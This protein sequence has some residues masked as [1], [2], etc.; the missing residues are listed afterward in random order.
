VIQ[1]KPVKTTLDRRPWLASLGVRRPGPR[2]RGRASLAGT[3]RAPSCVLGSGVVEAGCKTISGGRCKQSGM[4]WPESGAE[5]ILALRCM[6]SSRRLEEFWK[7][8]LNTQAARN[9]G[10]PIAG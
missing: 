1:P 10:L 3:F 4:V 2:A 8:R 9:D 6:H 5:N 7:H